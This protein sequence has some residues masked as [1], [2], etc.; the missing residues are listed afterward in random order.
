MNL[1]FF[2]EGTRNV[3]GIWPP[4]VKVVMPLY[5]ATKELGMH[6]KTETWSNDANEQAD[7]LDDLSHLKMLQYCKLKSEF[8]TLTKYVAMS[9]K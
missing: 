7:A 2:Y 8:S 5:K 3:K 6:L 4:G 9:T 1:C